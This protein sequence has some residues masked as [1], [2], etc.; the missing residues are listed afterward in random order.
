MRYV[1]LG[2]SGVKVSVLALGSW[3]TY[4]GTVEDRVARECVGVALDSGVNLI[5]T[6]DVYKCGEAERVLGDLLSGRD[7]RHVVLAT[8]VYFPMSDDVNDRGL[9]R[10]H[11]TESIDASLRRLRTDYVD[12]YQCHRYDTTTP[13]DEVVA[14][15]GDL[16]RRGKV[17]YWGVSMWRPER[18]VE[19]CTL[20]DA[21]NVPRPVSNQPVYS[22]LERGI[23]SAVLPISREYGLGQIAYSPLAQG[24]LTG[25][26]SGGDVPRGSRAAGEA[27]RFV[28]RYLDE[29]S[30]DKVDRMGRLAAELD[31]S[32]AQLALAWVLHQDGVASAIFGASRPE[33]VRE[34]V[35]SAEV[36]LDRDTLD[37]LDELFAS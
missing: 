19:A 32:H 16:V 26:Y 27:R 2:A 10:K 24:V 29:A 1:N 33:Q 35:A 25:K 18:I 15:M 3:L 21:L 23:E 17:L 13:T 36:E 9:S 11:V 5:D 6:A 30:L 14:T 12:L 4:G 8:K 7:R 20:A 31:L 28:E 37:R 22:L 34:N